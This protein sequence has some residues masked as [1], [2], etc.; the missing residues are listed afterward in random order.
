M[1]L[2]PSFETPVQGTPPRRQV[3]GVALVATGAACAG[4]ASGASTRSTAPQP[5][6]PSA[7]A[8][9][10]AAGSPPAVQP[11]A[12][13]SAVPVGGG[14]VLTDQQIVLTQPT[15]G[16]FK[17]F[18]AVC[19]HAGCTVS[20]VENGTIDCPC[21]GSRYSVADGA[22]VNGPAQN[23]L[24]AIAITVSGDQVLRG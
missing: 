3:L 1:T 13:T 5:P 18:T 17:A 19:T 21:H 7:T 14:M 6:A 2:L 22:V 10:T 4:C 16:V 9:G 20:K 11:L 8:G 24:A 12:A 15:A 23:P